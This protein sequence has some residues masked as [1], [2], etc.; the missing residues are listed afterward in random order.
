MSRAIVAL[1]SNVA[2]RKEF[3]QQALQ[4][5]SFAN[6]II[7]ISDVYETFGLYE[8]RSP[9]LNC[10]VEVETDMKSQ[11]FMLFLQETQRQVNG[12]TEESEG[13]DTLDCDL[14]SFDQE[15][16]RTPQLTL[17]HPEAHRRAFVMI[18]L[19]QINPQ[20]VH[21]LLQKSAEELAK[22]AYWSGWGT[23]FADGKSLLDF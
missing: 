20:W 13:K 19:A 2:D 23:F 18:P 21:P 8:R 1:G 14:I 17:P 6:K 9:Y 12:A 10:C 4:R 11:Q 5:F 3:I 22:G 15:V 16:I 7:A